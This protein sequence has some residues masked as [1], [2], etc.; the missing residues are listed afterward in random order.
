[1]LLAHFDEATLAVE[2]ARDLQIAFDSDR[3]IDFSWM[4]E[5]GFQAWVDEA[6]YAITQPVVKRML[7]CMWSDRS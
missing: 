2:S 7:Q 3:A 5:P 1:M 4:P 6:P